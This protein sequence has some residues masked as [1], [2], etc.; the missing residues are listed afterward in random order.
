MRLAMLLQAIDACDRGFAQERDDY[1]ARRKVLENQL[2]SLKLDI[3][4]GQKSLLDGRNAGSGRRGQ[5][6][7]HL[8]RRSVGNFERQSER[9]SSCLMVCG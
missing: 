1:K 4:T 5:H 6:H 3:I 2:H 9:G 8:K 7:D